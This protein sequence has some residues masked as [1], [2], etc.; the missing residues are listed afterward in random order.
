MRSCFDQVIVYWSVKMD[1]L[2]LINVLWN[3][4]EIIYIHFVIISIPQKM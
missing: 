4:F 1:V 2:K 3:T